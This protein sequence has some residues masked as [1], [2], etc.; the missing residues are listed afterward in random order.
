MLHTRGGPQAASTGSPN[1]TGWQDV[2]VRPLLDTS[3]VLRLRE[4]LASAGY[5]APGIAERLGAAATAQARR[6]DLRETL[7][8]TE[9][10]DRIATLIRLFVCGQTEPVAAVESALAPLPL[11]DAV[12]AG[13]VEPVRCDGRL[14]VRAALVL[15]PYGDRWI[16]SDLSASLRPG[17]PLPADHVLGLGAASAT[18][19]G[20]VVRGS[21]G[22]ALDLGTGCGVQALHLADHADRVTA[23]DISERALR[24]AATT[25]ALNGLDWELIQGDLTAP[26]RGRRFD[27]VVSNPPFVTGPGVTTHTYRDSGRAGDGVCAE[28][29]SAAP[30]LLRDGGTMQFLA[31]WLHVTGQ[32]WQDR[33]AGWLAD[34]GLDAWVVQ[35]DVSDPAGYVD[36]WLSDA[37][38]D[39]TTRP[40]RAAAW[41]DWFD[42]NKVEG[43]GF[44]LITLR[45]GGH[46]DP[47]V[48]LEDLRQPLPS[49]LGPL[50]T[51]WFDRQ[52][53]LRERPGAR[54]LEARFRTAPGL[55]LR[56]EATLGAAGWDVERQVVAE[57]TGLC[58][59][60]EVDPVAVALISGCTGQLALGTQLDLL[61]AANQVERDLLAEVA[62]P[63]VG[64]LVERGLLLPAGPD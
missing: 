14:G 29:A 55:V 53:W 13:L 54:L 62:L 11:A 32:P 2:P 52:D 10:G 35:R 17:R 16:L 3:G 48:R 44:G 46:A 58:W 7:R 9:T 45:A 64:Q 24:L 59:T 5:T 31:N 22:D 15:E 42:A 39:P 38:E 25:A 4:A 37:A 18:L 63:L 6:G 36:L 27:L 19:A 28:L 34:T 41:L 60:Q 20:A 43:I 47:T 1:I 21:V 26:V 23:T 8:R 57:T 61:A 56:Q 49:P 51:A 33:V 40:A 30:G 50:V 12:Q